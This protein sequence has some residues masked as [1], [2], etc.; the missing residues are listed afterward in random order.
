MA[1]I[2]SRRSWIGR[3]RD[4][5]DRICVARSG[6]VRFDISLTSNCELEMALSW[7]LFEVTAPVG[8][9]DG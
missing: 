8:G 3:G 5:K 9:F 1:N 6:S 7:I 2:I 4:A